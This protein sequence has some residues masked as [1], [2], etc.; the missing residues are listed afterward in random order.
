MKISVQCPNGHRLSATKKGEA[1]RVKCIKCKAVFV[2]PAAEAMEDEIVELTSDAIIDEPSVDPAYGSEQESESDS[3]WNQIPSSI[4]VTDY[5]QA[6]VPRFTSGVKKS[7]SAT[8]V[9]KPEP[10][11]P[12]KSLLIA[13]A[14]GGLTIVLIGS[15]GLGT[16]LLRTDAPVANDSVVADESPVA[17]DAPVASESDQRFAYQFKQGDRYRLGTSQK[18]TNRFV[19]INVTTSLDVSRYYEWEVLEVDQN[20]AARLKSTLTRFTVEQV[21]Q[22]G[23]SFF[24]SDSREDITDDQKQFSERLRPLLNVPFHHTFA[25]NG[26]LLSFE[27]PGILDSHAERYGEDLIET[28]KIQLIEFPNRDLE[29]GD[30]FE[31]VSQFQTGP[32]QQQVAMAVTYSGAIE[33]EGEDLHRFEMVS[34]MA[35]NGAAAQSTGHTI[36]SENTSGTISF[37]KEIAFLREFSA[38]QHL[39]SNYEAGGEP[40]KHELKQEALL[41]IQKL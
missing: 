22:A 38:T 14:V 25:R 8:P 32:N 41:Q 3:L 26:K 33:D 7:E 27:K 35:E 34:E 2:I 24:D 6:A 31:N 9:A 15:I 20:G 36:T 37:D 28:M 4:P 40:F 16:W 12:P 18:V 5:P 23:K 11:A 39:A 30:T 1:R 13:S 21:S 10:P 17:S 29:P 19:T